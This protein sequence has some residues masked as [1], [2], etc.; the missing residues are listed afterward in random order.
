MKEVTIW[1]IHGGKTGDADSLFLKKNVVAVGWAKM[2]DLPKIGPTR[3]GFKA[4]VA[5][6]YPDAK[7]GAIPNNAGQPY[8]FVHEMQV[9]DLVVYPSKRDRQVHIGRIEGGYR[10]DPSGEESYPNRRPVAWLK[11]L[12]RRRSLRELCTRS[13]RP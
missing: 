2:G 9:G 7:P 1:G 4:A 8:R 11:T 10:H 13:A 6:A 5:Q 12:P 3:D